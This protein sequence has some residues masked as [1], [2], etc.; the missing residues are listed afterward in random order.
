MRGKHLDHLLDL[1]KLVC[2][3]KQDCPISTPT[4]YLI[5]YDGYHLTREGVLY[6]GKLLKGN[7][8]FKDFWEQITHQKQ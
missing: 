2:G 6:I 7:K 4:G 3:N 1:H 5:S 8:P